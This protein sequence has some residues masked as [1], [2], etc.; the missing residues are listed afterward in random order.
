MLIR[1]SYKIIT[2]NKKA[3]NIL[4]SVANLDSR[5]NEC[6]ITHKQGD[7]IGAY[8]AGDIDEYEEY[9]KIATYI[10]ATYGAAVCLNEEL[11]KEPPTAVKVKYEDGCNCIKLVG[12]YILF[13]NASIPEMD[14]E[15]EKKINTIAKD[16]R[17]LENQ[18]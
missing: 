1:D 15:L 7:F 4:R 3:E 10:A 6:V 8:L 17:N 16:L 18:I 13:V 14:E 12:D 5:I 9:E 11:H 2:K